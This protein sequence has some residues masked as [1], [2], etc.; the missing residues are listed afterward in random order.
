VGDLDARIATLE[1]HARGQDRRMSGVELE[2]Y[3]PPKEDSIK[4]R[5]HRLEE[6][7]AIEKAQASAASAMGAAAS[8][9]SSK[10]E[11]RLWQ[12]GSL[13]GAAV[14]LAADHHWI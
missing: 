12:L 8:A 13:V 6:Y 11:R 7:R 1:E 9:M 2:L 4:G 14:V 5:L 10:R 3:G